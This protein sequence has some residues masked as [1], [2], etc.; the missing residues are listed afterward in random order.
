MLNLHQ[1]LAKKKKTD[2]LNLAKYNTKKKKYIV[3][4]NWVN[5]EVLLAN[6]ESLNKRHANRLQL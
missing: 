2:M 4:A 6:K 5:L 1:I 3:F